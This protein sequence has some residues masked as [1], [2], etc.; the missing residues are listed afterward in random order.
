MLCVVDVHELPEVDAA[1][2]R[3]LLDRIRR[4]LTRPLLVFDADGTLWTGDVGF[5]LFTAAIAR[6]ALREEA[7]EALASE[8]RSLGV[9]AAGDANVLA[10]RLLDAFAEGAYDDARAFAMMAWAF[11]GF[12]TDEMEDFARDVVKREEVESRVIPPVREILRWA[13]AEQI[14]V[15]VCSASQVSVV[16]AGVQHLDITPDQILA[17]VP[18]VSRSGT[19]LPRLAPPGLPYGEGKVSALERSRPGRPLLAGFGDSAGD[20]FFLRRAHVPVAVGPSARLIEQAS[21]IPGL[22]V[23]RT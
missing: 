5:D 12:S 7:L 15:V 3:L 19:L 6:K 17:A 14:E 9:S 1:G 21:S 18:E 13:Q 11:A 10:E 20:A 23:L 22:V 4:E 8:A 2:L 16:V